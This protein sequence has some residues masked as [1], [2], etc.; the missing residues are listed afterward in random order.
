[1]VVVEAVYITGELWDDM[2]SK[3]KEKVRTLEERYADKLRA[4]KVSAAT[5]CR[6]TVSALSLTVQSALC[7]STDCKLY[8]DFSSCTLLHCCVC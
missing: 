8:V 6:L 7:V 5:W 1:M 3:E 4:L 2:L